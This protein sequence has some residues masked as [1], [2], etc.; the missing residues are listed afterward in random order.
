M[1]RLVRL[2]PVGD[3][4]LGV[5]GF[6][7]LKAAGLDL[8]TGLPWKSAWLSVQ[9]LAFQFQFSGKSLK[10]LGPKLTFDGRGRL[11]IDWSRSLSQW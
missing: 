9:L 3:L 11:E 4:F 8:N 10:N 6:K 1:L 7:S 2:E 5:N